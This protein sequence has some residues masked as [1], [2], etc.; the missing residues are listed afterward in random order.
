[1]K[2]NIMRRNLSEPTYFF[3][4]IHEDLNRFLRDSFRDFKIDK[5]IEKAWR[6]ALEV[7]ETKDEYKI[8]AE[9]PGLEKDDIDIEL[10]ENYITIKGETEKTEQKD[11]E[12]LHMSEFRYGKFYRTI[13]MENPINPATSNAHFKNGVLHIELKKQDVKE[14]EVKKLEIT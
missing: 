1:M 6:P 14:P 2:F 8:K 7:K 13:A 3:D 12:N 9:L 4:N 11:E 10:H 5:N